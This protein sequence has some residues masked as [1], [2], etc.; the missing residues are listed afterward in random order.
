VPE[1]GARVAV[2]ARHLRTVLRLEAGALVELFD[3][4]GR[5]AAA[6][7]CD[8]DEAE[9]TEAPRVVAERT[10]VDVALPLLKGDRQDWVVEKL[11]E[12]GVGTL[13]PLLSERCLIRELSAGKRARFERIVEAACKQC[14]R[15]RP[16][17]IADMIEPPALKDA[18]VLDPQAAL[19][20][21]DVVL[22]SPVL[23]VVGPEGGLTDGERGVGVGARLSDYVLRAETAAVAAAAVAVNMLSEVDP[24]TT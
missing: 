9:V 3:A 2:P 17:R 13:F 4:S 15:N 20:L 5:C 19:A 10:L 11:C 22:R 6:R 12:L 16:M 21:K 24:S 1:R 14:G 7:L 8:G 23:L 18:I